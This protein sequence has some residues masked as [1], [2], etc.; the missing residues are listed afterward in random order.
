MVLGQSG[1]VQAWWSKLL[2]LYFFLYVYILKG[3]E[4]VYEIVFAWKPEIYTFF[5]KRKKLVSSLNQ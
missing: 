2:S 3:Q 5:T 1:G 4:E